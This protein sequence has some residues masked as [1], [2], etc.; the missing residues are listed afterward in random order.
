MRKRKTRKNISLAGAERAVSRVH[1]TASRAGMA[2]RS[3][4]GRISKGQ[5]RAH[6]TGTA[7]SAVGFL[8]Y[9]VG[10]YLFYSI[11]KGFYA[12]YLAKMAQKEFSADVGVVT[13][14]LSTPI[15]TASAIGTWAL[16]A[17]GLKS[18]ISPTAQQKAIVAI[19]IK[20]LNDGG[21]MTKAKA[22]GFVENV[23]SIDQYAKNVQIVASLKG[24]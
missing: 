1:D 24:V 23:V 18:T 9:G 17:T 10:A 2:M 5:R 20:I 11:G 15:Q 13:G 4:E 6:Q 3:Y 12:I 7:L 19:Q 21:K 16:Q 14:A 8:G 22:L